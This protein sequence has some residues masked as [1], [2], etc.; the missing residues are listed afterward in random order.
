MLPSAGMFRFSFRSL[1]LFHVILA[2]VAAEAFQIW[3][4][5]R[6]S[7]GRAAN[8]AAWALI[9]VVVTAGIAGLFGLTSWPAAPPLI[10]FLTLIAVLWWYA[11]VALPRNAAPKAWLLPPVTFIAFFATYLTVPAHSAIS[12]FGFDADLNQPWPLERDRLYLSLYRSP[13]QHYKVNQT[14]HWFG[15]VLRPGSTSMFAGVHMIN[16]YSPVGPSG[17]TRLLDFGTHGHIN[18]PRARE[19]VLPEAAPGGLLEQL[20]IDGLIVAWDFEMPAPLPGNWESVYSGWEGEIFHRQVPLPH[21]R[22]LPN[23]QFSGAAVRIIENSRHRVIAEITPAEADK[24][25]RVIFSRPYFPGYRAS[26]NG[27]ALPVTS[28][29]GLAPVVEIPAGQS[30][31]LELRYRPRSATLGGSVAAATLL[32]MAVFAVRFRQQRS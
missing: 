32:T 12:R 24:P 10:V 18:P 7:D 9:A 11:H 4:A 14:N 8:P 5:A 22:A 2:L 16:G 15:T 27:A 6:S 26:L 31:G 29:Q 23:D 21:V 30:G 1:P 25:T 28:L 17:I 20:G 13:P 3:S 19:I